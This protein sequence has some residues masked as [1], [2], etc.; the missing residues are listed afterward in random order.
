[1]RRRHEVDH[2]GFMD[3][4][5]MTSAKQHAFAKSS[6]QIDKELYEKLQHGDLKHKQ[7]LENARFA[8]IMA[9]KHTS[10]LLPNNHPKALTYIDISFHWEVHS[11]SWELIIEVEV[12]AKHAL[13]VHTEAMTAASISALA[14]YDLCQQD[15]QSIVLGPTYL[16]RKGN[17]RA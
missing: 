1:M 12:K 11:G 3:I 4:S 8:G 7:V 15:S 9:A 5:S 14:V 16:S 17:Q 10:T 6:V 2:S 13:P